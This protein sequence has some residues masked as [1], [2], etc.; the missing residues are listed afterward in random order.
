MSYISIEQIKITQSCQWRHR[1]H[2]TK[3]SMALW[4]YTH[5]H[6]H[7]RT[8][9]IHCTTDAAAHHTHIWH[10]QH[11]HISQTAFA[12]THATT[13]HTLHRHTTSFTTCT[14]DKL[15]LYSGHAHK[16]TLS[17][18]HHT[19]HHTHAHTL[20]HTGVTP[21]INVSTDLWT[22]WRNKGYKAFCC[23]RHRGAFR[24]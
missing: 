21:P 17:C 10:T 8:H 19:H 14:H 9:T 12:H 23:W 11:P 7:T 22:T 18:A 24:P 13:N 2:F 6:T 4:Y 16:T 1:K 20:H 3:S 5:T 15:H